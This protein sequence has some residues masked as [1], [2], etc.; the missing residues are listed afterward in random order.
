[1]QPSIKN[2]LIYLLLLATME[3]DLKVK[4]R[5]KK[6]RQPYI[7]IILLFIFLGV[8]SISTQGQVFSKKIILDS[9][10]V[11]INKITELSD[12]SYGFVGKTQLSQSCC[13]NLLYGRLNKYGELKWSITG[14]IINSLHSRLSGIAPANDGGFL[15]AGLAIETDTLQ[16]FTSSIIMRVDSSGNILWI[17]RLYNLANKVASGNNIIKLADNNYLLQTAWRPNS[18]GTHFTKITENGNVLWKRAYNISTSGISPTNYNGFI[19]SDSWFAIYVFDSLGNQTLGRIIDFNTMPQ[20]IVYD[21]TCIMQTQDNQYALFG[22]YLNP[23]F[24]TQ[25]VAL[26][27]LDSA[28]NFKSF[29]RY[30]HNAKYDYETPVNFVQLEDGGYMLATYLDDTLNIPTRFPHLIRADSSGNIVNT[31]IKNATGVCSD[32]ILSSNDTLL[33]KTESTSISSFT[34]DSLPACFSP[35]AISDTNYYPQWWANIQTELTDSSLIINA[36]FAE[37][38]IISSFNE[39]FVTP[40][41]TSASQTSSPILTL[42]PNPT[43]SDFIN[44]NIPDEGNYSLSI[45]DILGKSVIKEIKL[46]KGFNIINLKALAN[47]MYL[48]HLYENYT[49]LDK[50]KLIKK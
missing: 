18:P 21:A 46:T 20:Q 13:E 28:F 32:I 17:K 43:S 30:F 47:G 9:G 36:Q 7:F 5:L 33:I 49:H 38:A 29:T 48:Y 14:T 23:I 37:V 40:P 31:Y 45:Y 1:M 15:A 44:I 35:L 22:N 26:C 42:F 4:K 50:G 39:C 27:I 41:D 11:D 25:D 16:S 24:F 8:T 34:L 19:A 10:Y 2:D 12:G 6:I 3:R